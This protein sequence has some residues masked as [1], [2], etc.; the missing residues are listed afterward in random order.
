VSGHDP[1]PHAP[2]DPG[3]DAPEAHGDVVFGPIDWPAWS[4]AVVGGVLAILI[5]ISLAIAAHP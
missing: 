2:E 1:G 3:H 5:A 4:M